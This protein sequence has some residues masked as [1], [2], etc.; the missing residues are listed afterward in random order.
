MWPI[1]RPDASEP[2]DGNNKPTVEA[3]GLLLFLKIW[4]FPLPMVR[5]ARMTVLTPYKSLAEDSGEPLTS[6]PLL[7][8]SESGFTSYYSFYFFLLPD[9]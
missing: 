7:R 8:G 1:P 6:E 3:V 5:D 9:R 2:R 4:R